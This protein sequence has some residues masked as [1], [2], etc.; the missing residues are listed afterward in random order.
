MSY[1]ETCSPHARTPVSRTGVG[2]L[3]TVSKLRSRAHLHR[4]PTGHI[5]LVENNV[6]SHVRWPVGQH[7]LL[8]VHQIAGI[9]GSQF[10]PMSV[11]NRIG[12]TRFHAIPAK[13]A[14]VVIDVVDLGIALGATD[15]VLRRVLGSLDIDA[16]R[17]A[18]RGA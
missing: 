13:N 17:G 9:E 2:K 7:L 6:G 15:A 11:G 3:E 4:R 1:C 14:P 18:G 5:S 10:K 12:R 8:A 16:I